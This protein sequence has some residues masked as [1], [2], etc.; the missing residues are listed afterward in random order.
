MTVVTLKAIASVDRL[1]RLLAR[2]T[3]AAV[4]PVERSEMARAH[5]LAC[6]LLTEM[7]ES[8]IVEAAR[9]EADRLA[10]PEYSAAPADDHDERPA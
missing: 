3:L 9:D 2:A 7:E 10:R 8:R 6:Y 1:R 4:D 5:H